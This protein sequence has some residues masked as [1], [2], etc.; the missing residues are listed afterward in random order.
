ME[1][2]AKIL[3]AFVLGFVIAAVAS[4]FT[5]WSWNYTMPYLFGLKT[6]TLWRAFVLNILVGGLWGR[7]NTGAK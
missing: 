1:T 2:F 7:A 6:L 3:L 5:M 4:L